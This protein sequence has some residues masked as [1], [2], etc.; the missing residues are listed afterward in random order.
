M[1]DMLST[2]ASGRKQTKVEEVLRRGS[3]GI[4]VSNFQ[5]SQTWE[6]R[7][8]QL[9]NDPEFKITPKQVRKTIYFQ[10]P[11]DDQIIKYFQAHSDYIMDSN[12]KVIYKPLK[13]D[14][15]NATE[16]VKNLESFTEE[17]KTQ[18]EGNKKQIEILKKEI[19]DLEKKQNEQ[20]KKLTK[21]NQEQ[22]AKLENSIQ[23]L[24]E[25]N[26]S[27]KIGK[28][29]LKD[30]MYN[31]I[32]DSL[33][34]K[35]AEMVDTLNTLNG[36]FETGIS[37][38]KMFNTMFKE[39]LEKKKEENQVTKERGQINKQLSSEVTEKTKEIVSL[40]DQIQK[41]KKMIEKLNEKLQ[42]QEMI[43]QF[44]GFVYSEKD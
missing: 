28:F 43:G 27:I 15:E 14:L 2:E 35:Q 38:F 26:L 36:R 39:I 21:K 9:F 10:E 25:E 18:N 29:K 40:K 23:Q 22:V 20:R 33:I 31:E 5:Q 11:M 30:I 17:I 37:N 13:K 34:Q 8:E 1:D 7:E 12:G 44:K 24:K 42:D 19:E 41:Q 6:E 16:K 32:K 4:Q 3:E